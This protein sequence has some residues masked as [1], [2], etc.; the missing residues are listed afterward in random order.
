MNRAR[1]SMNGV[2][3][4]MPMRDIV[5]G[6]CWRTGIIKSNKPNT[7]DYSLKMDAY[8][9]FKTVRIMNLREDMYSASIESGFNLTM[10]QLAAILS[11]VYRR[12]GKVSLGNIIMHYNPDG[13][14]ILPYNLTKARVFGTPATDIGSPVFLDI[15]TGT[16]KTITSLLGSIVFSIERKHDMEREFSAKRYC[17]SNQGIVEITDVPEYSDTSDKGSGKCIFFIPKHLMQ[18]W[19]KHAEIAKSIVENMMFKGVKWT[20]RILENQLASTVTTRENEIVVIL[21]DLV[22]C[23]TAKYLEPTVRYASICFEEAG[24]M[25]SKNNALHQKLRPGVKFGRLLAVSADFG[26]WARN[27]SRE[28]TV[29]QSIIPNHSLHQ[30]EERLAISVLG[31]TFQE[32]ER[33][34]VLNKSTAPLKDAVLDIATV[35]YTPSLI[36]SIVGG[37]GSDLGN[38]KGCDIFLEKYGVDVSECETIS[39]IVAATH[40]ELDIWKSRH[41]GYS[42][43]SQVSD[44]SQACVA[45]RKCNILESLIIKIHEVKSHDCP[46]CLEPIVDL[47]LIQPCLHFTCKTCMHRVILNKKCPI[48][49]GSLRG[50]VGIST[51]D[52]L[53]KRK[54]SETETVE[55]KP[56]FR[57]PVPGSGWSNRIGD[58]FFDEIA[59]IC[60]EGNPV[61][62][63][64][65]I[66]NVLM[67]IQRSRT[68]SSRYDKTF[69]TMLICPDVDIKDKLFEGMGFDVY[70]YRT[71]GTYQNKV[72]RKRMDSLIERFG[73]TS[74]KSKLICVRDSDLSRT[75]DNMTGLDIPLDCVISIGNQNYAQRVG[76][77]CRMSRGYLPKE[78]RDGLYI[79][80]IKE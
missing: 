49:R 50:T 21:C 60:G 12:S 9:P 77:L 76:R 66:E 51:S 61:G 48:C 70:H 34:C 54:K 43:G 75:G 17:S 20:V 10:I 16:G 3:S 6:S 18:H 39:E 22:R 28:D 4:S 55:T 19:N 69:R 52:T 2:T 80:I 38:D 56:V 78:E 67:S 73:E 65:A 57:K 25:G 42:Q 44:R 15:P 11:I 37:F 1:F 45:K 30:R 23:G 53:G 72:T 41:A 68:R 40:K 7:M 35:K 26:K 58:L 64:N 47:S 13:S 63:T 14:H 29:M 74:G 62:I 79:Q 59:S 24:E 31:S 36:E 46:V 32:N 33:K 8:S 71:R 27:T 5:K